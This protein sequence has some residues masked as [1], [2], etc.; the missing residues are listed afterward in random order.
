[1][2][3]S[4]SRRT[5]IPAF[6]SD[7]F[8]NRLREGYVLVRNPM[9]RHQV[10]RISLTREAVDCFVFWT[11]NPAAMLPK[12]GLMEDR[13]F[14]FQ[15]TLNPYDVRF[16]KNV[17]RKAALMETFKRLS[18]ELGPERVNWRYD[19]IFINDGLDTDYHVKCFEVLARELRGCTTICTISF[20][21]KYKKIERAIESFGIEEPDDDTK[22]RLASKMSEIARLYGIKLVTCAE[23]IDLSRYGADH[24][25]CIGI[26][27][28]K[29]AIQATRGN[30]DFDGISGKNDNVI[31][32]DKKDKNQ[33]EACGCI[34][35][36]DIG[37]YDTCRHGCIYCYANSGG[38]RA[39]R[40]DKEYDPASP[41]LC[42][43]LETEDKVFERAYRV[44]GE[45]LDK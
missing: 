1:M 30:G 25:A 33:R 40:C 39:E 9:N 7:W 28:V 17:P 22:K 43:R 15:F 5:D 23:E 35:S 41:L 45:A 24:A 36:V 3:I 34:E 19:P 10:S 13:P 32:S 20:I 38:I 44:S 37:A 16:E 4:A 29:A 42:S 6:Y 12:L 27:H 18:A 14:Y 31:I 2:I 21:D 26:E 11:K 8:F